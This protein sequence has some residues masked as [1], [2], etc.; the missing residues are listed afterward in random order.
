MDKIKTILL[1]LLMAPLAYSYEL[2][3]FYDSEGRLIRQVFDDG[4]AI[5]YTYDAAGNIIEKSIKP[6]SSYTLTLNWNGTGNGAVS[7]G[8]TFPYGAIVT[9]KATPSV[10]SVF[11]EWKPSTC[12]QSFPL[13][14]NTTCSATFSIAQYTLTLNTTGNGSGTVSGGGTYTYNTLVQP[15]ASASVGSVFAGWTPSSCGSAFY[16]TSN[17]ICTATFNAV[18]TLITTISGSGSLFSSP[19]GINCSSG[20]CNA[21]F[22]KD[23]SVLLSPT[24]KPGYYF[25]GWSGDCFGTASCSV[26]M[27]QNKSVTATFSQTPLYTLTVFKTGKGTVSS[28]DGNG[29]NCGPTCS[30]SYLQNTWVS[31]RAQPE[32]GN[33]FMGW[34]GPCSGKGDC[35]VQMSSAKSVGA[36][37]K[38]TYTLIMPAIN[39]LLLE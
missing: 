5:E 14:S 30:Y 11:N 29:I 23:T 9:P 36:D 25:N 26:S 6:A 18:F 31:L 37:F 1:I 33:T 21:T 27:T 34:T 3:S 17:T 39:L 28:T 32:K 10:G 8:G 20:T 38:N 35:L 7:G 4:R 12:A 13:F 2:S 22:T 19:A 16:L 24:A 15:K